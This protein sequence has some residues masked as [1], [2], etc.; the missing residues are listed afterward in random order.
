MYAVAADSLCRN[1]G[2]DFFAGQDVGMK[3]QL[4]CAGFDNV[5]S[6]LSLA[7][8]QGGVPDVEDLM[9]HVAAI[10]GVDVGADA[11]MPPTSRDF[12]DLNAAKELVGQ[13]WHAILNSASAMNKL[14]LRPLQHLF[15]P[16]LLESECSNSLDGSKDE[17]EDVEKQQS[18][19]IAAQNDDQAPLFPALPK[20]F[21]SEPP[22]PDGSS[23]AP[24]SPVVQAPLTDDESRSSSRS[25][26]SSSNA[27]NS[28]A[29]ISSGSEE[30]SENEE[31]DLILSLARVDA[32]AVASSHDAAAVAAT[33]SQTHP[34]PSK[35][36][37]VFLPPLQSLRLG[38]LQEPKDDDG[39]EMS[40]SS[41]SVRV[42]GDSSPAL[43][44]AATAVN[45]TDHDDS[46]SSF[47]SSSSITSSSSSS[48]RST[49]IS[50]SDLVIPSLPSESNTNCA[51]GAESA[52]MSLVE[53]A[54]AAAATPEAKVEVRFGYWCHLGDRVTL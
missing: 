17:E 36:T 39:N 15:I 48:S 16:Q 11:C 47:A 4:A 3:L 24:Q 32:G 28:S 41:P 1:G 53:A 26:G 31:M 6:T 33:T 7:S 52:T 2:R 38:Q 10:V 49:S 13:Q 50:L 22:S 25:G 14:D 27:D 23:R 40:T 45:N 8:R 54:L 43:H 5:L 30:N 44:I 35:S 42:H 12:A 29:D 34:G 21:S 46:S 18:R 19:Q 9:S 20:M 37:S 51:S